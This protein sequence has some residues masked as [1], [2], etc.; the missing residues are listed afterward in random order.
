MASQKGLREKANVASKGRFPSSDH[1]HHELQIISKLQKTITTA[2]QTT[3][4]ESG[5]F[6]ILK[7][8]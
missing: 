4:T 2:L 5:Q 6:E 7:T 3:S 8:A 1:C